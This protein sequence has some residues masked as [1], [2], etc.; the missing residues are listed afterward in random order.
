MPL[1]S[2]C[3]AILFPFNWR[4]KEI[5]IYDPY[6]K[7]D[8]AAEKRSYKEVSLLWDPKEKISCAQFNMRSPRRGTF[9]IGVI[10]SLVPASSNEVWTDQE[11]PLELIFS[12]DRHHGH[13]LTPDFAQASSKVF[14]S[15]SDVPAIM[16]GVNISAS[17][18]PSINVVEWGRYIRDK[19]RQIG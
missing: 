17:L 1:S 10:A 8:N 18:I 19:I 6:D 2:G 5:N 11:G 7:V 16:P 14:S 15:Q 13:K 9:S 4:I 12:D 3:Y